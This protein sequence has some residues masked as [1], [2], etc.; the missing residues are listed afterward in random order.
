MKTLHAQITADDQQRK[1]VEEQHMSS[2]KDCLHAYGLCLA[3]ASSH[4]TVALFR[5]VALWFK[6]AAQ[7][8]VNTVAADIVAMVPSAKFLPLV[9]QLVARLDSAP[10][11]GAVSFQKTLHTLVQR[12]ATEHPF[13]TLNQLLALQ[14][15]S[16]LNT[17][18]PPVPTSKVTAATSVLRHVRAA[19][20]RLAVVVSQMEAV[21]AA[22]VAIAVHKVDGQAQVNAKGRPVLP[23][24]AQNVKRQLNP[25]RDG[26]AV[27]PV[28][29][30]ALAVDHTCAY[31]PGSFPTFSHFQNDMQVMG[32][33]NQPKRIC[34]VDSSGAEHWQLAKDKDD[35]RQDAVMQQVFVHV[36]A[37]LTDAPLARARKL[38]MR[39]YRV[40]PLSPLAGVME[41]VENTMPL[42]N[43]LF[44]GPKS[45]HPRLRPQDISHESARKQLDNA[46]NGSGA[47]KHARLRD[48]Y[49][50]ICA[51]YRPVLHH[52]FLENFP[53]AALWYESRLAYTRSVA[54]GSMVGYIIGLGDRHSSNI[55]IVDTTGELV[56]IDLGIAFEQGKLLRVPEL[57]PF[58]LTPDIVD[59][60]GASGVE[61]V[62]RRCSEVTLG[63]LRAHKESVLTL[64]EVL[65]HDP[66]LKWAMSPELAAR[67]QQ[68]LADD[69]AYDD[70][71]GTAIHATAQPQTG[72]DG[73]TGAAH[74]ARGADVI[75]N[76]DVER[77]LLRV[78][79]KLDGVEE[80]EPRSI[81]GQVQQLIQDARDPDKLCAMYPGW[82]PWC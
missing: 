36:S 59:G 11:A 50:D 30:A 51:R 74:A 26:V 46:G 13:H 39:S 42:A 63:V 47:G 2:L 78:R 3:T 22:Y 77:A 80:G 71:G 21:S 24:V 8:A 33:A 69:A 27:V 66:I 81:E 79:Q 62:M 56:H 19:S 35:L 7:P 52:F 12:L 65:I 57:V 25:A 4:D 49:D 48:A 1:G 34:A 17:K 60:M 76:V 5:F 54:V 72:G 28:I 82:A 6:G 9:W 40:V 37:L 53:T 70:D 45:A 41:W 31:T 10:D 43:Y 58:R 55:L 38:H 68:Q 32:G 64:V 14:A 61:G 44:A 16:Q 23:P 73:A 20:P 29:T 67:R 15:S 18:P 75:Q